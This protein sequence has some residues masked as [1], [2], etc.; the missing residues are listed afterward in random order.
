MTYIL[1]L[2]MITKETHKKVPV[3]LL[4]SVSSCILA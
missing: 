3:Q 1:Y 4:R 2:F